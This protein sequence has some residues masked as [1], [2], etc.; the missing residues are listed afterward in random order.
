[1]H[2]FNSALYTLMVA[3]DDATARR[4]IVRILFHLG[5][6]ILQA[7]S[8]EQA[9]KLATQHE[10]DIHILLTDVDLRSTGGTQLAAAM[11]SAR[12][13]LKVIYM[14]E[15]AGEA[16]KVTL[17]EGDSVVK[18]PFSASHLALHLRKMLE[19]DSTA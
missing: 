1:M 15:E 4:I 13:D 9:L 14:P 7:E 19:S 16:R 8:S 17:A 10:G 11:K 3:D 5:Y 6:R 2:G 18:K 12:P